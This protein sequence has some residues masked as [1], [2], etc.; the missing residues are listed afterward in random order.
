MISNAKDQVS[1]EA[2]DR[3]HPVPST[4]VATFAWSRDWCLNQENGYGHLYEE[5]TLP[6]WDDVNS[7]EWLVFGRK[8]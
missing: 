3:S 1:R 8:G 5:S 2:Y 4:W 6:G 7:G